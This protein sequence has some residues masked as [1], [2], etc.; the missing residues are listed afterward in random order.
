MNYKPTFIQLNC[1]LLE[2]EEVGNVLHQLQIEFLEHVTDEPAF[3][4]I[5][6]EDG[7]IVAHTYTQPG[8]AQT[9]VFSTDPF[10][11]ENKR[12]QILG[13]ATMN[14]PLIFEKIYPYFDGD[15][16]LYV[17]GDDIVAIDY[18]EGIDPN[19]IDDIIH[20]SKLNVLLYG[21]YPV[22]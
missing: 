11:L 3:Q 22:V 13:M 10:A 15:I 17:C 7:C 14:G 19:S 4:A 6:C 12:W 5:V 16:K 18:K 21:A 9:D 2:P 20:E 1:R 8:K